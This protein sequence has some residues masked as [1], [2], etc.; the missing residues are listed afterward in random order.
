MQ[1][2]SRNHREAILNKLFVFGK[3]CSSQNLVA[4]IVVVVKQRMSDVFHVNPDLMRPACF[5]PAFHQI[6]IA[7][8]LDNFIMR[9]GMFSMIFIRKHRKYLPVLRTSSDVLDNCSFIH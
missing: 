1:C 9:D 2:L 5:E 4:T 8:P 6:Y 7:Q 3:G